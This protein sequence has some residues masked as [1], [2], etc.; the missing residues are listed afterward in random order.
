MKEFIKLSL[1]L[2]LFLCS[3]GEIQG[4]MP[5]SV[6]VY[7]DS[8]LHIMQSKSLFGKNLNWHQIRD[9]AYVK[10][11]DAKTYSEAFPAIV[12][13]FQQ[14]KDY[15]GMAMNETS[16]YRYPP[17][18]NF[19][20]VLGEAIKKEFL[21]GPRI[22]TEY[23]ANDIGYLR[24]PSMNI[25]NQEDI[26]QRAKMLRDSLC[27]LLEKRPKSLII[28]LRMNT[29]G[30]SAPMITGIEPLLTDTILG[31]GV[32]R[33]GKFLAPSKIRKGVAIDENGNKLANIQESCSNKV[34]I[35][36]AVLIGKSTISSGEILAVYLKQQPNVKV[37][38]ESTPGFC[39]ATEGFLFM[40]NQGYLLLSVNKIADGKKYVYEELSVKPD[41]YVK[42]NDD[43][44]KLLDDPTISAAIKWLKK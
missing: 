28:D 26:D 4:Q 35:P 3:R 33:D 37:F 1:F 32:D 11:K 29:G 36:M 38:G 16:S 7:I 42:S 44:D 31:Y 10:A 34:H 14:L 20:E 13:G 12:Y 8:A 15:H 22:V 17:P 2:C 23:L 27:S 18:I 9:S 19:D 41:V 40:K 5:V 6:K 21:K 39:S 25:T 43:Y 30:N 24:I